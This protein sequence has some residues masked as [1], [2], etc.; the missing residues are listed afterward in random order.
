MWALLIKYHEALLSGLRVTIT[1]CAFVWTVGL[2]L[3]CLLGATGSRFVKLV[4]FPTR[5]LSFI[6]A[7]SP[8][9][10]ILFWLHYPAQ[11]L[12]GISIDGFWTA[13]FTLAL[14]MTASVADVVRAA[15]VQ[16]PKEYVRAG[17]VCGLSKAD[18]FRHI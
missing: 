2:L 16:F 7:A 15:M 12:L 14:V 4:G 5:V 1:M 3:G 10:I 9:L 17:L 6:L 11:T 13:T 8:I 18:I